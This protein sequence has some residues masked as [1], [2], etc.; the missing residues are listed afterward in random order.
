MKKLTILS[1]ISAAALF[2]ASCKKDFADINTD[3]SVVTT[4][5]V[6]ALFAY[7]CESVENYQGT[8]WV[9]ENLEQLLRFT[10]HLTTDPYELSN[11]V[12]SRYRVL[13]NNVLPNLVEI[14]RYTSGLPDRDRYRNVRAA[15]YVLGILQA[16]KTTDMNGSLPY[17]QAM[18]ARYT[19]EL[20]PAYDN[21]K[22]LFDTW[23]QE[24]SLAID[25]LGQP[26]GNQIG[27]GQSD[28]Y[29]ANNWQH[30]AKLANSLKLRIA[31]RYEKADVNVTK[32]VFREVMT[33]AAGPIDTDESQFKYDRPTWNPIGNDIDYRSPR[34]GTSSI[35]NFLKSTND[36]R[37]PIYFTPND[38]VGSFKDTLTKYSKTLPAFINVN[39][40]MVRWQG[41]PADWT[42]D[43]VKAT[44]YKS[45]FDAGGNNKWRLIGF[46][47][48]KFFAPRYGSNTTGRLLDYMVTRAET[49]FYIAELIQK[50]H[51]TGFDTKGSAE[52]WYKRGVESSL[53]TMNAIAVAAESTTGLSGDGN[54]QVAAYLNH[55]NVKFNGVNDLERIYIQEYLNFYRLA[56]EAFTFCRR[57][58]YPKNNSA[59]YPRN[60]W[61]EPIPRRYALDEPAL[62]TN[63]ENWLKAQQE[64]GFTPNDRTATTLAAQRLWFDKN[65][66]AFG[67]G[68]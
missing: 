4:P 68:N 32:R 21:Q 17:T 11:N 24:L 58:G 13:Y 63:N 67:Q 8:E 50:G 54:A 22:A 19:G 49:S 31:V 28:L 1:I 59:F 25:T 48:K 23:L 65:S 44:W 47:N 39:D 20:R 40:P 26:G 37:L 42:T 45:T 64:Q 51:G 61:N 55:P 29:Y 7:S 12:N 46:I 14:R 15:T 62:G 34:F 10:Q 3:P 5:D 16:L 38:L 35:I 27:F 53:R 57:T 56:N 43:P 66:P 6:A 60:A 2:S 18:Q 33:S 41:G 52:D 36:P 30:W 9:W